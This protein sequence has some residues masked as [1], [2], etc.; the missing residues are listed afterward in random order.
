MGLFL[1][2]VSTNVDPTPVTDYTEQL[3]NNAQPMIDDWINTIKAKSHDSA[4]L[5]AFGDT[6][7]TMY[8]TLKSD[9]FTD[10]MALAFAAADLAGRFDVVQE[11]KQ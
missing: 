9:G 8:S 2:R 11:A 6:L 3:A 7:L 5:Q 1:N 10:E 4:D